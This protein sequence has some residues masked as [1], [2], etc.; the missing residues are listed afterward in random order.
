MLNSVQIE[1]RI[2]KVPEVRSM[3]NGKSTMGFSIACDRDYKNSE[4][5]Y[6]TDFINCVAFD[7]T[8]EQIARF[9][10]KG[11]RVIVQGRLEQRKFTSRDGSERTVHEVY[12]D[13][14]YFLD[15][16]GDKPERND[17][18]SGFTDVVG[19]DIPF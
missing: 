17:S 19:E 16:K 14:V 3:P 15:R 10:D 13:R 4:G 5:S 12:A 2:V 7:K 18:R 8:A 6:V 1:G 11:S 9:C